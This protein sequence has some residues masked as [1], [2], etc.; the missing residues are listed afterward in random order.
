MSKVREDADLSVIIPTYDRRPVLEA[1]L[2]ALRDQACPGFIPE[3][4]VS[5]DGSTD[6]TE[7][8]VKSFAATAPFRVSY[9]RSDHRG[10]AFVRNEGLRAASGRLVLFI[11]D[12]IIPLPGMLKEHV[13]WHAKNPDDSTAVFGH[14]TWSP[15]LR[16]TPFMSWLEH[17][18]PGFRYYQFSHGREVDVLWTNNISFKRRFLIENGGFFDEEFP[19][20]AMEDIEL[21]Y[22]LRA[23]GLRII[24]NSTA[25]AHHYHPTSILSYARRQELVGRSTALLYRKHPGLR[26][27]PSAFPLWKRAVMATAPVIKWPLHAADLAGLSVDPRVYDLVLAHYLRKGFAEG[28][29][30]PAGA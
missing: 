6:G 4:I 12:D 24:Y 15:S 30:E 2:K 27:E 14:V 1:C 9:V 17:G 19:Y 25:G 26:R 11:G 8:A 16:I 13:E 21:G 5:D 3:V 18:G 20:A 29:K 28:E 22:R 23:R 7:E 10:P